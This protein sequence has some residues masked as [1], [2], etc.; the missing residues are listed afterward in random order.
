MKTLNNWSF[1]IWCIYLVLGD[2]S[3]RQHFP[4]VMRW[5]R[6]YSLMPAVICWLIYIVLCI[7]SCTI[8]RVSNERMTFHPYGRIKTIKSTKRVGRKSKFPTTYKRINIWDDIKIACIFFCSDPCWLISK[9]RTS[10]D[11]SNNLIIL[12]KKTPLLN[13]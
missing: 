12:W 3:H 2:L 6:G 4:I 8:V 10:C 5:K 9:N 7:Y 13:T 11:I 1:M